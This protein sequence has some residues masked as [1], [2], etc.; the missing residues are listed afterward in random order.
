MTREEFGDSHL[1]GKR[2]K[3]FGLDWLPADA[4]PLRDVLVRVQRAGYRE[5][6]R[7]PNL[8]DEAFRRKLAA[9]FFGNEERLSAVDDL[10]FLQRTVFEGRAWTSA[11]VIVQ[12]DLFKIKA[13]REKW[14]SQRIKGYQKRLDAIRELE[15]KYKGATGATEKEMHRITAFISERWRRA[16]QDLLK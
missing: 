12:P 9:E 15:N 1:V 7:N 14:D 10:L 8:K 2:L 6:V 4:M 5:F 13:A 11:S 16:G 3:P